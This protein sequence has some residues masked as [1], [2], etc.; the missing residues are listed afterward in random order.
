MDHDS[1]DHLNTRVS[2][3]YSP[4]GLLPGNLEVKFPTIGDQQVS[5]SGCRPQWSA[6]Q[7]NATRPAAQAECLLLAHSGLFQPP[8]RMSAFR[9]K[10]DAFSCSL[11]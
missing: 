2:E 6:S 7:G 1:T 10:A 8:R 3:P 11:T 9:G 5:L 4:T